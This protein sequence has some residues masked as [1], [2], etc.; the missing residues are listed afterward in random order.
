MKVIK[1][2]MMMSLIQHDELQMSHTLASVCTDLREFFI[3]LLHD[4]FIH[5]SAGT[6]VHTPGVIVFSQNPLQRCLQV[7]QP[8]LMLQI[9][10]GAHD[11]VHERQILHTHLT[12]THYIQINSSLNTIIL[13]SIV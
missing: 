1:L 4:E 6:L 11:S 8:M 2:M 10:S 3:D 13:F 5:L 9:I 12:H 7:T